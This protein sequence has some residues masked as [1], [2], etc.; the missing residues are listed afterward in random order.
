[1]ARRLHDPAIDSV[2]AALKSVRTRAGLTVERL[3]ATGLHLDAL[4]SLAVVRQIEMT[5]RLSQ[6]RAI[7]AAVQG[8]AAQLDPANRLIVD[9]A[10]ALGLL[11]QASLRAAGA[12]G[13]YGPDLAGR[14]RA[15]V[16]AWPGLHQALG[17][18][19]V[20]PAPTER[21]LR[22]D[23]EVEAFALLAERLLTSS[24][25]DAPDV[26][27]NPT[28]ES[29]QTSARSRH[30]SGSA[31]HVL[32]VG[33]A[34]MDHVIV[35]DELPEVDKAV[36]AHSNHAFPGGKGLNQ[37][38]AAA[39]LGMTVHLLATVG[40][41]AVSAGLLDYL[42]SEN[43]GTDLVMTVPDA[44]T[45]ETF[46]IVTEDGSALQIGWKN[47]AQTGLRPQDVSSRAVR[48]HLTAVDTILL[49]LEPPRETVEAILATISTSR[50]G[51]RTILT[52]SPPYEGPSV[53]HDQLRDV[54]YLV[55]TRSELQALLPDSTGES[56]P[57]L[58]STQLRLLGVDAVCIAE[59]FSS[60]IRTPDL[61]VDVPHFPTV[62]KEAPGARDAFAAALAL[63]LGEGDGE[64]TA[65]DARWVTAAMAATQGLGGVAD[66]MPTHDEIDRVLSIASL[67]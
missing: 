12:S 11:P 52:A 54:D 5:Q 28:G 49:T 16:E 3:E 44:R 23:V 46:L 20:P 43:V 14:R 57:E 61:S 25:L 15:L 9:A 40:D 65:E 38:V 32:V 51:P 48:R 34:V 22:G 2:S 66:A 50:T 13:L 18:G 24:A 31:H 62:Q 42:A 26:E 17:T 60:L 39:R 55:G 35:V 27:P 59:E 45:A 29:S 30:G 53:A 58:L 47:E 21:A 63:R 37:A 33:A 4:A 8:A 7:V 41:D 19:D 10:L 67:T 64:P 6:A 1:M 36:Q 56:S